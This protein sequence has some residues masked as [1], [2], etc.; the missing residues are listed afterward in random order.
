MI[1]SRKGL[2]G[3]VE[4]NSSKMRYI[5]LSLGVALIAAGLIMGSNWFI[6]GGLFS[7]AVGAI[8]PIPKFSNWAKQKV[9]AKKNT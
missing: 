3:L 4:K 5:D 8:N 6:A 1:T 7:L 9:I 2:L